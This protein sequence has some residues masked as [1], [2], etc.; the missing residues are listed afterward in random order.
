MMAGA[1]TLRVYYYYL[2]ILVIIIAA[3]KPHPTYIISRSQTEQ[4]ITTHKQP[5]QKAAS[6][7]L[8]LTLELKG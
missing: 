8:C 4:H 5:D 3:N 6:E 1:K 7:R 2:H